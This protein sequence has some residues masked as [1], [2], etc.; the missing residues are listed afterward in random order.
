MISVPM[1]SVVLVNYRGADDTLAAIEGLRQLDWPSERLQI[2]VVDNASGDDSVARLR[3]AGSDVVLIEADRNYGFA[4]GCN[5]GARSAAEGIVAFL[6]NDARPHPLWIRTAAEL[7]ERD[8]RVGCVASKVLSWDGSV[9]DFV[10]CG[11]TFY[12]Q[13]FKLFH[14]VPDGPEWNEPKD[15][16]FASGAAMVMPTHVFAL[17]GGFD[18]R[19][20]M[21]FEDVDLGWRTWLAGYSVRYAPDSIVY[22]RHHATMKK[23]G[24][25]FEEYLL[26]RNGLYTLFKNLGDENLARI[27]PGALLLSTRRGIERGGEDPANLD[28][29]RSDA[30]DTDEFRPASKQALASLHAQDEFL[31][32]LDDLATTRAQIQETRQ[33]SDAEIFRLF[34]HPFVAT[35]PSPRFAAALQDVTRLFGVQEVFAERRR[36][37]V[38]T[39]DVV[40]E[41]MAGPAIRSQQIASAL[42]REHDVVLASLVQADLEP[43]GYS[44]RTVDD[45]SLRELVDWCDI[46]IFQGFLLDQHPFIARRDDK[47]IVVDLYD[48]FHLEQLEAMRGEP[49]GG[50]NHVNHNLVNVLNAQIRR[51][52]FFMCASEKQRDFWLGQFSALD[53]INPFVYDEDE[54][55]RSLLAVVPFGVS[56]QPPERTAPGIRDVVP[57][58]GPDDKVILWGGGI[59]NW[60][61]PSTLIRAVDRLRHRVP[62]VRLFFMGTKH[63][64]PHVPEMRVA[65]EAVRL[66]DELGLLD[67]FVFFNEGWVPYHQRQNFLLDA[68]IGVSTHYLHV[69]TSFSFRTRILDYF[70]ANLPIVSTQGDALSAVINE[71]GL[72]LTVAPEDPV[73]LEDALHRLLTDDLFVK[74]CKHNLDE[75]VADFRWERTLGPLLDFCRSAKRAADAVQISPPFEEPVPGTALADLVAP[76]RWGGVRQDVRIARALVREGGAGLALR[77]VGAR[78]RRVVKRG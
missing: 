77:H 68:D 70:W 51:G 42:S 64:N 22:H 37:L 58:I 13:A 41:R 14:D 46:I 45:A 53:R 40:S 63:P 67:R 36:I 55:L 39:G 24:S 32:R 21:F 38:V 26:E 66:A 4:G 7:L 28:L 8:Q 3:S 62:E 2:I 60:F 52:D 10:E 49:I 27:L 54:S 15:V 72:G 35:H 50:R 73:A 47:V 76:W 74:E 17:L 44:V 33:R 69:E 18:Q 59:Y 78:A 57:G 48:P 43:L 9:T 31:T 23:Y 75:A 6:N 65:V 61:D 12:G 25:W 1:A 56:D 19:Y 29:E 16:L 20:F 34:R 11:Q 5:I 30:I 71:R